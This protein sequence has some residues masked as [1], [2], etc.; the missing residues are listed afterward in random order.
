MSSITVIIILYVCFYFL[1]KKVLNCIDYA[2]GK[3]E[4]K[5]MISEKKFHRN[6]ILMFI[7]GI[8]FFTLNIFITFDFFKTFSIEIQSYI[9]IIA[10]LNGY[11]LVSYFQFIANQKII[12]NFIFFKNYFMQNNTNTNN[13]ISKFNS[14]INSINYIYYFTFMIISSIPIWIIIFKTKNLINTNGFN[15]LSNLSIIKIVAGVTYIIYIF[16]FTSF[17]DSGILYQT[18][19]EFIQ[20][21]NKSKRVLYGLAGIILLALFYTVIMVMIILFIFSMSE[22]IFKINF[23]I[24]VPLFY[25]QFLVH[26]TIGYTIIVFLSIFLKIKSIKYFIKIRKVFINNLS[27]IK[28]YLEDNKKMDDDYTKI[29]LTFQEKI[30]KHKLIISFVVLSF[31][32]VFTEFVRFIIFNQDLLKHGLTINYFLT[33]V[34][35][36]F[37]VIISTIPFLIKIKN[38]K[39]SNFSRLNNIDLMVMLVIFIFLGIMFFVLLPAFIIKNPSFIFNFKTLTAEQ[40]ITNMLFSMRLLFLSVLYYLIYP[41]YKIVFDFLTKYKSDKTEIE[42]AVNFLKVFKLISLFFVSTSIITMSISVFYNI[43]HIRECIFPFII[44]IY[45]FTHLISLYYCIFYYDKFKSRQ[46]NKI[47]KYPYLKRTGYYVVIL[48]LITFVV[49]KIIFFNVE[50]NELFLKSAFLNNFI[51]VSFALFLSIAVI[52]YASEKTLIEIES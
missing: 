48:N 15:D 2:S 17:T 11:G 28:T 16:N 39:I 13:E 51:N 8:I 33:S 43:T 10:V 49:S 7:S 20:N 23:P 22:Y 6:A 47:F 4:V 31:L 44:V 30:Q 38:F 40:F 9:F 35:I 29:Y 34:I 24:K 26:L 52:I 37:F 18:Q 41:N 45:F 3:I 12:K 1:I 25:I 42:K 32:Y 21:P 19:S 50:Q 36:I 27:E 14:K 46:F 5:N